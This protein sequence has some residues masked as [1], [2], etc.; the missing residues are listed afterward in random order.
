MTDLDLDFDDEESEEQPDPPEKNPAQQRLDREKAK[1]KKENEELRAY[2]AEREKADHQATVQKTFAEVGLNPKWSEFYQGEEATPEA[3]K[4][5]ALAKDFIQPSEDNNEEP[6]APTTGFT[7]TV[8]EGQP[9]GT[10]FYSFEE[11]E[12]IRK[13]DPMKADGLRRAGRV[14]KVEPQWATLEG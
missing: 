11:Y 7:P 12:E 4:A 1:L 3:V 13:T 10:K 9:L 5:W 14:Q 8:I 2:K 6:A